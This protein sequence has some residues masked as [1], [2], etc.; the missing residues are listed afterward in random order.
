M[1]EVK[2]D[3]PITVTPIEGGHEIKIHGGFP[4]LGPLVAGVIGVVFCELVASN[5]GGF[6]IVSF[7]TYLFILLTIWHIWRHTKSQ[8]VSIINNKLVANKKAYDIS[9]I[10]RIEFSNSITK[11]TSAAYNPST[12]SFLV[13]TTNVGAATAAGAAN[14]MTSLANAS[15]ASQ[16]KKAF[17]VAIFYGSKKIKIAKN[18]RQPTGLAFYEALGRHLDMH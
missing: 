15:H 13:A 8:V 9:N 7:G 5:G 11:T 6:Q 2:V 4:P 14:A 17:Y 3:Q 12:T 1:K 18:M 16:A 10:P